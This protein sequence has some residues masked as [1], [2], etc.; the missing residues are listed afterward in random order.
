MKRY[1]TVLKLVFIAASLCLLVVMVVQL[2]PLI[3]E[4]VANV[5]DESNIVE[6]I[7]AYGVRGVPV[8]ISL[9]ALQYIVLVI[10]APAVGV[11][12]GLCYGIVW[13]PLIFLAGCAIGNLFVFF[14]VRQLRGMITPREEHTPKHKKVLSKQQLE[15]MKRP[16]LVVFFLFLIPG[17]PNSAVPYLFATTKIPLLKYMT[18]SVAGS[19]PTAVIYVLLGERISSGN[20]TAAIII[21]AVV[22]AAILILLLFKKK[23]M[24]K[25]IQQGNA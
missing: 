19:A 11:L 9:S 24:D 2:F 6:Y 4:I 25:I 18:A 8:L 23:I 20:H 21:A 17:L 22:L 3:R 14:S 12:I 7:D 1:N 13:G 16:E 5:Y 15:K 10:P